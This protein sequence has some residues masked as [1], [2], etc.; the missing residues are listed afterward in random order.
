[1]NKRT[2]AHVNDAHIRTGG[3]REIEHVTKDSGST[4]IQRP[5]GTGVPNAYS[6]AVFKKW[7]IGE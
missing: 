5:V 4:N 7:P 6:A 3:L 2:A 1:M